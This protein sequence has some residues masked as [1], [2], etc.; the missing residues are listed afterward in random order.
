MQL[1]IVLKPLLRV[2]YDALNLGWLWSST[3][4]ATQGTSLELVD[5]AMRRIDAF[6]FLEAGALRAPCSCTMFAILV[7][8]G[9]VLCSL[10]RLC[11]F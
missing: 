7:L 8:F 3:R 1:G 4:T 2:V 11:G 5:W 6:L 9:H 10:W